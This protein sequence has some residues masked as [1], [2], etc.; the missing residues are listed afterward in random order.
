MAAGSDS[1]GDRLLRRSTDVTPSVRLQGVTA[2]PKDDKLVE[3][4]VAGGA[5]MIV[6]G[7][8]HLLEHGSHEG[9]RIISPAAF[10]TY[11]EMESPAE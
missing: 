6:S 11:L 2:Y 8:R 10:V 9:I 4:A 7:D 5:E 3:C 1:K